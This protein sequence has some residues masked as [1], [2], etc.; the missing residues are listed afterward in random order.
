[1]LEAINHISSEQ[2][3]ATQATNSMC[4]RLLGYAAA[5]RNNALVFHASDIVLRC[6]SDASYLSRNDA[7]SVV[8]GIHYL[9]WKEDQ[10]RVNGGTLALSSLVNIVV[11][12]DC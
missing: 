3:H 2:A 8:G 5:N 10:H 12:S 4:D 11:A 9:G 1:M 7:R 6:Q